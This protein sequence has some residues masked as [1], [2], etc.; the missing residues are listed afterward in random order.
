[1]K[2][3]TAPI[4]ILLTFLLLLT[5]SCDPLDLTEYNTKITPEEE[6]NNPE[7]PEQP[8]ITPNSTENAPYLISSASDLQEFAALVKAISMEEIT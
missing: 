7:E 5:P 1:M 4:Y 2:L 3:S 6:K 8:E